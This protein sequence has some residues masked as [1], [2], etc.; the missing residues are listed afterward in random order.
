MNKLELY[1]DWVG[2]VMTYAS[3]VGEEV[4]RHTPRMQASPSFDRQS[5]ILFMWVSTLG[6]MPLIQMI[7]L[8]KQEN[9]SSAVT[10]TNPKCGEKMELGFNPENPENSFTKAGWADAVKKGNYL[11][12]NLIFF[13]SPRGGS[14]MS[15]HQV[16]IAECVKLSS[17]LI[18][19]IP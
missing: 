9:V 5:E 1:N 4:G 16:I 15:D 6:R 2:R 3:G 19:E 12:S 18:M 13:G 7:T 8:S 14:D 17:E 11:F 10:H